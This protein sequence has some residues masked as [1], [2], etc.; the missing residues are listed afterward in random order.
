MVI[1][2]K[3]KE[4]SSRAVAG[5]LLCLIEACRQGDCELA[6]ALGLDISTIRKLDKL[7]PEQ[8]ESLSTAYM[9]SLCAV[10][11][12]NIDS[13]KMSSI[14]SVEAE[15]T[16]ELEMADEYLTGGACKKLMSAHFGWRSTQVANRKRFLDI[17]TVKGRLSVTTTE[18]E[19]AIYDAWL[20]AVREV[21]V[22]ERYLAVAKKTEVSLSKIFRVIEDIEKIENTLL[23]NK[24]A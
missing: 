18:E 2:T 12:F 16:R 19:R 5:L 3:V 13:E 10:A 24:C 23:L 6:A 11:I 15:K 21:D 22:R 4:G 14:I 17:P 7:K 9:K 8:I 1:S 20:T